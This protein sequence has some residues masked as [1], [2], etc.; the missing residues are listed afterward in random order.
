MAMKLTNPI[1][2]VRKS[3]FSNQ[4]VTRSAVVTD[5]TPRI[6]SVN[7]CLE[8]VFML[9]IAHAKPFTVTLHDDKLQARDSG[10]SRHK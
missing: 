5:L 7:A 6:V 3:E 4:P 1:G 2:S 8:H 9:G 10:C